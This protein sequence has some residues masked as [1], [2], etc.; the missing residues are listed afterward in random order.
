[1][2]VCVCCVCV[3]VCVCVCFTVLVAYLC[4]KVATIQSLDPC[5]LKIPNARLGNLLVEHTNL[6]NLV[7]VFSSS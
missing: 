1:M 6:T 5:H 4:Y 3:C 2:C 7:A